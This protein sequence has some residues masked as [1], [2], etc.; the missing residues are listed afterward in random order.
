MKLALLCLA[1]VFSLQ[2]Q[3]AE[4][5]VK[6]VKTLGPMK[7][8]VIFQSTNLK[9]VRNSKYLEGKIV[10]QWGLYVFEVASGYYS[11]NN[12]NVCSL[13]DYRSV[14]TF[15]KC[16]VTKNKRVRCSRPL[17][18]GNDY[19]GTSGEITY[20]NPDEVYDEYNNNRDH[21]DSYD[22][23][24]ARGNGSFDGGGYGN[25]GFDGGGYF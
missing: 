18:G 13:V 6:Q 7:H 14:A 24:P 1:L 15:E 21:Y 16:T 20:E 9:K 5:R 19:T 25:G 11:C 10:A 8:K 12:K 17:S 3:A 4:L 2:S 23:F 22:E